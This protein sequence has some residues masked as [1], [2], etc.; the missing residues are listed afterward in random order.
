MKR[1][2]DYLATG[3]IKIEIKLSGRSVRAGRYYHTIA[4]YLASFVDDS[5]LD[6]EGFIGRL[7]FAY[8]L[9]IPPSKHLHF[10]HTQHGAQQGFE[11]EDT[12][13]KIEGPKSAEQLVQHLKDA[14]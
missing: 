2:G 12:R 1:L 6:W 8:I 13:T 7:I 10:T 4:K 9:S 3:E 5:T 11:A 14:K